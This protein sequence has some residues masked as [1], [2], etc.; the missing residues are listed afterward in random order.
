MATT[1]PIPASPKK[2][3]ITIDEFLGADFTNSPANADTNKSPNLKNLIRDVP[4]KVR[5]CMG[6]ERVQTYTRGSLSVVRNLWGIGDESCQIS[7]NYGGTI[8]V[9]IAMNAA[10]G[11]VANWISLTVGSLAPQYMTF[12]YSQDFDIPISGPAADI[13]QDNMK[14]LYSVYGDEPL[15]KSKMTYVSGYTNTPIPDWI[16]IHIAKE[17]QTNYFIR[18]TISFEDAAAVNAAQSVETYIYSYDMSDK[19]DIEGLAI[20]GFYKMR[21][22]DKGCFHVGNLFIRDGVILYSNANNIRSRG[23]EF[24]EHYYIVDG[25]KLLKYGPAKN[26]SDTK[27]ERTKTTNYVVVDDEVTLTLK[28]F[29]KKQYKLE[30]KNESTTSDSGKFTVSSDKKTVQ[31]TDKLSNIGDD[32]TFSCRIRW[33]AKKTD[34]AYTGESTG[35]HHLIAIDKNGEYIVEPVE[36]DAYTPLVTISK[37]PEGGGEPYEDLNLLQPGFTEQ[38]LGKPNEKDYCLSFDGLDEVEPEVYVLNSDGDW[39]QKTYGTDFTCDYETGVITFTVAPGESPVTGEDNVK[40]TAYR[41]VNDYAEKINKCTIGALFGVGGAKDRLFLSGNP[42]HV[43]YDWYSE[44]Y[45]P[46][47]FPD[48]AYSI[49]GSSGSAIIGY[50]IISNYLAAHKDKYEL[51]QNIILREGDLVDSEPSFRIINTL[52]GAGAVAPFS[53]A[54]LQTE[55]LFLTDQGIYAVTAQDITGEKYAQN[56]SYFLDGKL[57]KEPDMDKAFGFVWHD[58]Y[59]LCLNNVAYILDGLQPI[60]TDKSKPYATRQYVGFYRTNLPARVMWEK[61]NRL[62]FGDDEGTVH[63]FYNDK[64]A[65][66]SYNDNGQPI[67]CVWETPDIIGKLF[68]KNKTL[69][70]VAVKLDSAI[71]ASVNFFVMNRGL[72]QFVKTDHTSARYFQFSTIVFSKFSF[73]CDR[74][75]RT[76]PSKIRVKKVDKFRLKLTNDQLNEPFGL[77]DIGFEYI[78]STNYKG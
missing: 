18:V 41:T 32:I 66:E 54:Y 34:A 75:Q 49:L 12:P 38:F 44:R 37:D 58:M 11:P 61:D 62:Y 26:K 3:V 10:A 22:D 4:G 43:N 29:A 60:Q 57:L 31:Y 74:T 73:S 51:D 39:M 46:T 55:P 25:K 70:H 6:Y 67:E 71:A 19:L 7:G 9:Q 65:L 69:R 28:R 16:D 63:R 5:K 15:D 30:V 56:R 33:M 2:S 21:T 59:W 23:W 52:Q 48:T 24:D 40:V 68:F 27:Y 1:F 77:Y 13:A 36:N 42:D 8:R 35:E 20:N 72:W 45:N 64:Y 47:Y 14:A 76:I 50:S 53:F 78:E 17:P